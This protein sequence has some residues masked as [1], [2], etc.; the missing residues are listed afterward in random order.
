MAGSF[1]VSPARG[2]GRPQLFAVLA[3]LG[4][5]LPRIVV[6]GGWVPTL[7]REFG[8]LAW[9]GRLSLTTEVDV[10]TVPPIPV[11]GVPLDEALE[12]RGFAP[13]RTDAPSAVWTQPGVAGAQ[14]EFL[15]PLV[16]PQRGE[17]TTLPFDGHG[18]VGGLQLEGLDLLAEFTNQIDIPV[19]TGGETRVL[20]VRVPTLGAY[21]VNKAE[22]F[23]RRRQH[24][25]GDNPKRA[26]DLLYL[27]DVAAAGDA[28]V[29]RVLGDVRV[30]L[31]APKRVFSVRKA[32]NN[33][34]M[35]CLGTLYPDAVAAAVGMLAEREAMDHTAALADVR[36]YLSDLRDLLDE[37]LPARR[38][39]HHSAGRG[40]A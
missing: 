28:V 12:A 23:P 21:V 16:G 11:E 24:G 38:R 15:T 14:I 36:G 30:I 4:S 35:T 19:R 9:R 22:T 1:P 5:Y 33:L 20:R 6:I 3:T 34:Q 2:D 8:G 26:K 39:G 40:K 31:G 17:G 10:L 27:R 32:R 37:V 29:E 7:Y 13:G 25:A 18:G